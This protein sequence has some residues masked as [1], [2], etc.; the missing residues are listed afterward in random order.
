M[1]LLKPVLALSVGLVAAISVQAHEDKV[2]DLNGGHW[3]D[4]GNYHCH[5]DGCIPTSSRNSYRSRLFN[6]GADPELYY[7]KEDW[8]HWQLV[9]GCKTMRTVVLEN[10]SKVPVTWTNPRQCEIREG[11]WIDEYTGE[12]FTR[13]AQLEIDH[14]IP[15]MYA[16]TTNGYQWDLG[17]RTAFANDPFNLIPVSRAIHRRKSDRAIGSWRPREE[18]ECDYAQAWQQVSDKYELDLLARDESRMNK[19]LNDCGIV[20]EAVED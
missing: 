18:F 20:G 7:L 4:W 9:S 10:T 3:D 14:I 13:A 15:P 8:P 19:I 6:N 12:E 16:N 5:I 11:L 2:Y 1:R 17:K